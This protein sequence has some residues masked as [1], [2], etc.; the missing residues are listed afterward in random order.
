[1]S[2]SNVDIWAVGSRECFGTAQGAISAVLTASPVCS[3]SLFVAYGA[4]ISEVLRS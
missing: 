1:M 2:T 3:S 4:V